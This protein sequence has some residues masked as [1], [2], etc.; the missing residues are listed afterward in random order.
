LNPRPATRQLS[1]HV[2]AEEIATVIVA[3]WMKIR[4]AQ[5]ME[6]MFMRQPGES[7]HDWDQRFMVMSAEE[8]KIVI[9]RKASNWRRGW[10]TV[11]KELQKGM[12]P[13]PSH[14]APT[15]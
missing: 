12:I 1:A 3:V 9:F 13:F 14:R 6:R 15:A 10:K 8:Q 5:Q 2:T 4:E 11:L 7:V